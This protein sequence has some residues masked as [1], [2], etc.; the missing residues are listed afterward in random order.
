MQNLTDQLRTQAKELLEQQAVS[1]VIGY[2]AT[3]DQGEMTAVFARKPEDVDQLGLND[4]CF[5]NLVVYLN[6]P[7]VKKLGKA[8]IVVKGC[9]RRALHV[10]CREQRLARDEIHIIGVCC[11]GVGEPRMKKCAFCSVHNPEDCD[12]VVGDPVDLP[13]EEGQFA[14]V[15][16]LDQM[17][18]DERWAFWSEKLD[19]CIRCYACRQA[20]PLCYCQ[21]CVV[22]KNIPQWVES[23]PHLRGNVAWNVVRGFHLTGR[24]IGCGECERVC[25]MDIPI[26]LINQKLAKLVSEEFQFVAGTADDE[27]GPFSTYDL[28]IDTDEG[29]L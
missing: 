18:P 11:D 7:N 13:V 24:C 4:H 28:N 19:K 23:S 25:P 17:P 10:L 8:A 22:E 2:G 27:E 16:Q 9:D 3:G 20:C 6:K 1:V 14:E 26:G 12:T 15:D 29:I 5:R 21:R